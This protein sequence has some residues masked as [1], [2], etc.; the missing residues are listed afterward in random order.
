MEGTYVEDVQTCAF[1][2]GFDY[3]DLVWFWE[4]GR[5]HAVFQAILVGAVFW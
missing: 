1:A 3:V 2:A 5:V 4:L